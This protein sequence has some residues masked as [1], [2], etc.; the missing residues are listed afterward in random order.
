M[1]LQQLTS[2]DTTNGE[3]VK[4]L[5]TQL[6]AMGF[7]AG[8][9]DG[10]WGG[11]TTAAAAA[12]RQDLQKQADS[13]A[14]AKRIDAQIA[15]SQAEA[16]KTKSSG[17]QTKAAIEAAPYVGGVTAGTLAGHVM[18][19]GFAAKDAAQ[20]EAAA[21]LAEDRRVTPSAKERQLN[22]MN[23]E[24]T[25]RNARQ[26]LAPAM[27]AGMGYATRNYIAPGVSDQDMRD[28]INAVG[29][30][31]NAAAGTLAAHQLIST[32]NRGNPID[33]VV[34]ARIRSDANPPPRGPSSLP[35][36]SAVTGET[37]SA[38]PVQPR[39]DIPPDV[40][41]QTPPEI[42]KSPT[43]GTKAHMMQQAG[44]LGIK[45]RSSMTKGQLADAIAAA[46]QEHGGKRTVAKRVASAA[47]KTSPAI[48]PLVAGGMAY[49]AATSDAEAAGMTPGEA[50]TRG[51]VAGGAAGG[52]TAGTMYGLNKAAPIMARSA[53]GRAVLGAVPPATAALSAFD[54]GQGRANA[55]M[56]LM[57]AFGWRGLPSPPTDEQTIASDQASQAQRMPMMRASALEIPA[58]I[59]PDAAARADAEAASASLHPRVQARLNRMLG[60]GASNEEVAQFLNQTVR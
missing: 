10:R 7:Y 11:Q 26:F 29:T 14:E 19:K 18:G 16:E 44:D 36:A 2:I 53:L 4:Q 23:A 34:Q 51:A 17:Q 42:P 33:P 15:A 30:G 46:L 49:D 38:A 20:S 55:Q 40:P 48:L 8:P 50:R 22:Q 27:L 59:S 45:G 58:D 52:A 47:G 1:D 13:Q 32:L 54:T 12:Y 25:S 31:E 28:Y 3:Q 9:I 6:K 21:R 24:R 5:Q 43:P 39:P 57:N 41:P 37:L 56:E 35:I 60:G